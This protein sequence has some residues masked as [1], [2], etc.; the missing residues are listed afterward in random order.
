MINKLLFTLTGIFLIPI[1]SFA[2][3]DVTPTIGYNFG[4]NVP[5]YGGELKVKGNG[6]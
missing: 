4:A 6:I 1:M 5:I 3:L 2:Q